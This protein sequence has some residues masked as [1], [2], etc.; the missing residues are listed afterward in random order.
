[1]ARQAAGRP[2]AVFH[3]HDLPQVLQEP[4][5][6]GRQLE[7][8]VQ[9]HAVFHGVAEVPEP[10]VADGGQL[11][12]HLLRRGLLGGAPEV[13]AV[14]AEAE[15]ADFQ[16]AQRLLERLLEGPPD[17]HRL[18]HALHL[19]GQHGVGLGKFLEGE[20]RHLGHHVVDGGLETGHRFPGDVVGQLVQPVA[21]RQLGGDLGDGEPRGL[22]RQGAGAAHARIHLDDHHAAVG[23]VDGELDVRPARLHADLAHHRDRGVAHAADIPCR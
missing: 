13:F 15:A 8:L 18:A 4:G 14:A 9:R 11:R 5:V 10:L 17:R 22:R 16:A 3:L 21:D 1:M 12:P 23:R 6:D 2:Q 7:D 20:P 19:R